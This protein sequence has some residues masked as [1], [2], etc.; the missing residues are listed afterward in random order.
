MSDPTPTAFE[1][2]VAECERLWACDARH[3]RGFRLGDRP[4]EHVLLHLIEEA[5]EVGRAPT[6]AELVSEMGDVLGLLIHYAIRRGVTMEEVAAA[7]LAKKPQDFPD[8]YPE[9]A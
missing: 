3:K 7:C 1:A 8:A 6:R 4:P 9:G 2:L 5:S